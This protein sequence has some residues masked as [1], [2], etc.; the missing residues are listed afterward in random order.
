MWVPKSR[1]TYAQIGAGLG[2]TCC[3]G[4]MVM[5]AVLKVQDAADRMH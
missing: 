4:L 2:A 5:S 3:V 1:R